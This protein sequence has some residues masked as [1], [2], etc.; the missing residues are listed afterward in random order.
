MLSESEQNRLLQ[1]NMGDGKTSVIMPIILCRSADGH[2]LV[3]GTVLS[4][5]YPENTR[6]W[7]HKVGGMLGRRIYPMLC[8]RDLRI[9]KQI[10]EQHVR[11]CEMIRRAGH[12]VVT[13][14]EHRLSL[15]NKAL[16]SAA[17][18]HTENSDVGASMK[19]M[20]LLRGMEQTGRDFLDESD[21]LLSPKYQL[22]YTLGAPADMDGG[23]R[24]WVTHFAV[25]QSVGDHALAMQDIF[26]KD[27]VEVTATTGEARRA[28]EYPGVRLLSG[29]RSVDAFRWLRQQVLSDLLSKPSDVHS[30][31]RTSLTMEER[32]VFE[33]LA[34]DPQPP[35]Q[36][37]QAQL[38]DRARSLALMLRGILTHEVLRAVLEK[39]WRVQYGAH[40]TRI[41]YEMAVPY[42]GKDAAQE[43]T[44][45][46]HPDVG[47]SLTILHY[48][49]Q[50]LSETQLKEVFERLER[51]AEGEKKALYRQWADQVHKSADV[52]ASRLLE[53]ATSYEGV[54]L[55]DSDM[56]RRKL[57]PVFR[58]H[59]GC[60]NFWLQ[61]K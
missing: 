54:N 35:A 40:P 25:I 5:L 59:M 51:L 22:V 12:F 38:E 19:L 45:F 16:E 28:Y 41:G 57:Y 29:E 55:E 31:L 18:Q 30:S 17:L 10:A 9:T 15:V 8:R 3:R 23:V 52:E 11:R 56:F 49:Q 6:D 48:Y 47:L 42:R 39:R 37:Q 2:R 50:G 20:E 61:R 36:A 13:V 33:Q 27:C 7:Q 58:R 34:M 44:E 53:G 32:V 26:G 21:E 14:P 4:S 43:Q 60:I 46:G 1:L 24:R